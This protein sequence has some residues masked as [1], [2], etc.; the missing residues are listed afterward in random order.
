MA[1]VLPAPNH[2]KT[3]LKLIIGSTIQKAALHPFGIWSYYAQPAIE[4]S[5]ASVN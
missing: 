3:S 4:Q 5:T 2:C 1:C